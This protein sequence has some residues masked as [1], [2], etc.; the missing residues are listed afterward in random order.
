MKLAAIV[1]IGFLWG[2]VK[3]PYNWFFPGEGEVA[4]KERLIEC[5]WGLK[6]G[7][8][9][10]EG[11]LAR[12]KAKGRF[13]HDATALSISVAAWGFKEG[14]EP[15]LRAWYVKL[16]GALV[17]WPWILFGAWKLLRIFI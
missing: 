7:D 1:L 2:G 6:C 15:R 9:E 4:R 12:I 8:Q 5:Q 10:V 13:M 3:F 11:D 16:A 17:V 14:H